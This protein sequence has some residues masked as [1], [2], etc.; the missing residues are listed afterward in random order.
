MNAVA[1]RF[2]Q[3]EYSRRGAEDSIV[4]AARRRADRLEPDLGEWADN[5]GNDLGR[6]VHGHPSCS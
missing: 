4:D 6:G 1:A 2:S 5:A 3:I